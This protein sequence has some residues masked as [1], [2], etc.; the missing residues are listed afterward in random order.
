M[1]KL[2][3]SPVFALLLAVVV[4]FG[5][6]LVSTKVKFGKKSRTVT[7]SFYTQADS[8]ST[9]PV[10]AELRNLCYAAEQLALT[11]QQT[12]AEDAESTLKLVEELRNLLYVQTDDLSAVY[13][14]YQ[15]LLTSTFS[16]ERELARTEL[17]D[18]QAAA[19]SSAQHDAALAKANIDASAFNTAAARFLKRYQKFPTVGLAGMVGVNMPCVFN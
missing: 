14:V 2:F 4:M 16:L 17:S 1:K 10:A 15:K 5:S 6:M 18:T 7:A 8:D 11:G 13:S 12:G 9:A 3:D 19:V